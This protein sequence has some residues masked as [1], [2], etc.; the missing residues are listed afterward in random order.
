[1]PTIGVISDTHG[2][3]PETVPGIFRGV[4]A[5]VHAG[6]VGDP[7]IL[8]RLR[9]VAP[10]TAVYG[11]VDRTPLRDRLP[12][13]ARS[14]IAG[15]AV[16]VTHGHQYGTPSPEPLR[17]SHPGARLVCFGHTHR[18]LVDEAPGPLVVNPGSAGS[19]RRGAAASVAL[20]E[21]GP[22]GDLGARIVEL[23]NR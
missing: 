2:T 22:D 3:L 19:P 1:M 10:V 16:V 5:I 6:D 14:R 9:A 18:A 7:G 20:V 13:V 8:D 12:L 11:N 15:I 21:V 23:P 17:S 4:E